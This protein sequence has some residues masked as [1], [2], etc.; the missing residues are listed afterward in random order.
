MAAADSMASE[1]QL[2]QAWRRPSW[3]GMA[4]AVQRRMEA[5]QHGRDGERRRGSTA[6]EQQLTRA[7]RWGSR[8]AAHGGWRVAASATA[9]RTNVGWRAAGGGGAVEQRRPVWAARGSEAV[10]FPDP[11]AASADRRASAACSLSSPRDPEAT[12]AA[13]ARRST[14]LQVAVDPR[15]ALQILKTIILEIAKLLGTR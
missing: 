7:R 10:A 8:R 12:A 4:E 9:S 2:A 11:A 1:R 5:R 13:A 6:G 14:F 3:R 15:L